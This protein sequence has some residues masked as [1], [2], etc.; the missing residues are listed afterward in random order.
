MRN[1]RQNLLRR[2]RSGLA[3]GFGLA[4]SSGIFL[5]LTIPR[6][7]G[8]VPSG[9]EKPAQPGKV[10]EVIAAVNMKDINQSEE[11]LLFGG[12]QQWPSF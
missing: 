6:A 7:N 3:K 8:E 2:L 5:L 4:L 1:P 11:L 10:D 9:N 12:Y